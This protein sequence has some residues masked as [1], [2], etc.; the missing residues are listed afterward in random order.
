MTEV[1][2]NANDRARA[3]LCG[4]VALVALFAGVWS[5]AMLVG[6][7]RAA[8][9]LDSVWNPLGEHIALVAAGAIISATA[10]F[11]YVLTSRAR[12]SALLLVI[13]GGL[14]A[15]MTVFASATQLVMVVDASMG[16]ALRD[17]AQVRVDQAWAQAKRIDAVMVE[18]YRAQLDHYAE[19]MAEEAVTGRGPRYRAAARIRN[20]LRAEYAGALGAVERIAQQGRSLS[21]DIAAVRGY[22]DRLRAKTQI[23]ARFAEAEGIRAPAYAPRIAAVEAR[24]PVT[25]ADGWLDRQAIVY[26]AVMAKLVEMIASFG[27][28]DL[29][30]TLNALLSITPDLIHILCA[31]LLL[32]LR[33]EREAAESAGDQESWFADDADWAER[34]PVWGEMPVR[35]E[36]IH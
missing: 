34:T 19:L 8:G 16:A 10:V 6:G 24:L 21:E 33:P 27:M 14:V 30:F 29:G 23:F 7:I 32:M 4:L 26:A 2:L 1:T 15:V 25:G 12:R 18:G 13:S 22:L 31:C 3:L 28:A 5:A 17:G 9:Q 20:R 35:G 36:T 11:Y